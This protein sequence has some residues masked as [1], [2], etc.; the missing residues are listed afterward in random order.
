MTEGGRLGAQPSKAL[1]LRLGELGLRMGRLKTGTPPRL[2]G[3]TIDWSVLGSQPG[4]DMPSFMSF[5]T[6]Q[7]ALPQ[8]A[9]G[10]TYTNGATHDV[11]R[12]A[13]HLS[14]TYG[15]GIE[16]HGPRY[17]PSIEDKVHRFPDRDGHQIFL[18]P[19]S[20]DGDTVY[21]NGV[22]TSLP[23]NKQLEFLRTISGLQ[24]VEITQPGY[25]VEYSFIDPRS[26]TETLEIRNLPGLRLAGQING[27]T[28]YEEAAAQGMV[29]GLMSACEVKE[30][31]PP[32]FTRANSYI[33]VMIDDLTTKGVSEPYRM[34]TSRAEYRLSLRAD[35]ADRRLTAIGHA[36]GCVPD[37]RWRHFQEKSDAI[38]K[39]TTHLASRT[40]SPSAYAAAGIEVPS[41]GR[42]R[43]PYDLL[44]FEHVTIQSLADLLGG[45]R[46]DADVIVQVERDARY[47]VYEDRQKSQINALMSDLQ[48]R[49][50]KN[51]DYSRVN[52]L[53]SE[54]LEKLEYWRPG[55]LHRLRTI[56][57]VTAAAVMTI[58]AHL[59]SG[60]V[61]KEDTAG[62]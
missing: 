35:N 27:T 9:C 54:V 28:G 50:P 10:I 15:G 61:R 13:I 57:G 14:A 48:T 52:G 51:F 7:T 6:N 60:V 26:L 40:H 22:S 37:D 41:D 44:A 5:M 17:C 58:A 56:E 36:V 39:I 34:F 38:D 8:I 62:V 24:G 53:S 21:P 55:S 3:S 2:R 59:K 25:A 12:S 33:G 43:S 32:A 49:I 20:L 19:E 30:M 31:D 42:M 45:V 4:D 29:A 23:E 1:G 47:R 46:V 18:E 11:I 16:A